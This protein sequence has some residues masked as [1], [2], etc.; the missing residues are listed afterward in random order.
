MSEN[1]FNNF[2]NKEN[3]YKNIK[4]ESPLNLLDNIMNNKNL[5]KTKKLENDI[6][7][8][9]MNT[10]DNNENNDTKN[11]LKN[12]YQFRI[13]KI[14]LP[15]GLNIASIQ[16]NNKLLQNIMSKKSK[17]SK[18]F[19]NN[20]KIF[21]AQT[22]Y[23]LTKEENEIKGEDKNLYSMKNRKKNSSNKNSV[24]KDNNIDENNIKKIK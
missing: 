19:L 8:N 4:D 23:K 6:N 11:Q 3:H 12:S 15:S 10:I 21:V 13:R 14:N 16:H 24:R 18:G 5:N 9:N 20:N 2:I 1:I 22:E 7:S 17:K